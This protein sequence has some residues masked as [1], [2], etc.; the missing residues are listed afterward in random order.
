MEAEDT[1]SAN[2]EVDAELG[3][4]VEDSVDAEENTAGV[5]VLDEVDTETKQERIMFCLTL[6][7]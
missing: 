5:D 3:A 1:I 7:S 2:V 6:E 4:Y